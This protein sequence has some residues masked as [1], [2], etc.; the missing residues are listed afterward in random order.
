MPPHL[1]RRPRCRD[2]AGHARRAGPARG[3]RARAEAVIVA[4]LAGRHPKDEVTLTLLRL[5]V[6]DRQGGRHTLPAAETKQGRLP[7]RTPASTL[8]TLGR[9]PRLSVPPP[10][11]TCVMA[12]GRVSLCRT[13]LLP[14]RPSARVASASSA[15]ASRHAAPAGRLTGGDGGFSPQPSPPPQP[16]R[17]QLGT[18]HRAGSRRRLP[19]GKI[20]RGIA[21]W[22]CWCTNQPFV[23]LGRAPVGR[24]EPRF[25]RWMLDALQVQ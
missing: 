25:P 9:A 8:I 22:W 20:A 13:T 21:S 17:G 19:P 12:N 23:G 15:G 14:R 11:R 24:I 10:R 4:A 2:R 7:D 1:R 18:T 6:L 16:W 3:R 5:D